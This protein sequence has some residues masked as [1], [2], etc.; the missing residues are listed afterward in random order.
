MVV[1]IDLFSDLDITKQNDFMDHIKYISGKLVNSVVNCYLIKI[2]G[3]DY[4][5]NY[6]PLK[7]FLGIMSVYHYPEEF[8]LNSEEKKKY[9]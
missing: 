9:N 7:D 6:F 4:E 5:K 3:E 8:L 2:L 1:E